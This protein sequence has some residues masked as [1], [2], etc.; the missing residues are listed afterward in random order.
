MFDS[1]FDGLSTFLALLLSPLAF[2]VKLIE[3]FFPS[4]DELLSTLQ[5]LPDFLMPFFGVSLFLSV[6][7]C[8]IKF[9]KF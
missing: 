5:I 8:V 4:F 6:S 1:F 2:T 9:F 7:L 3:L